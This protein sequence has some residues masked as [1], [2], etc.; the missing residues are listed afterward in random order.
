MYDPDRDS[1][2]IPLICKA[3]ESDLPI[4]GI[5]RGLQEINVSLGGSLVQELK[6][7]DDGMV[8]RAI[9]SDVFHE[10]FLPSHTVEFTASGWMMSV[11]QRNGIDSLSF[12][13]NSLHRQAIDRL[14]EGLNVEA[15]TS[16][17]VIEMIRLD[18]PDRFVLG[19]QWHPEWFTEE[20]PIY[21]LLFKEFRAACINRMQN[22]FHGHR[23]GN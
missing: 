9:K 19:V 22:S 20:T 5:C 18:R 6:E 8:H 12:K 7:A 11:L 21:E 3:I 13:T 15:R 2:T 23:T 10:K 17:G 4:L 1:T 14:G 16:D